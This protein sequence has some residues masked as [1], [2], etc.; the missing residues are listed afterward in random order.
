MF[1]LA[2]LVAV[3]DE[4]LTG[5]VMNSNAVWL[6]QQL[7][8]VGIHIHAQTVVGDSVRT[9]I[10][11]LR[12]LRQDCDLVVVT[13]GLGPT[14]DDVTKEA[15]AQLYQRPVTVD[16]ETHQYISEHHGR[17]S[18]WEES[19]KKQASVVSGAV[20]WQNPKG[21]AP[22]EL[23]ELEG[24][25]LVL[26]PGP[27]RE[28]EAIV[29]Q[30]LLPWLRR[31]QG[32]RTVMRQSL[33]C[34][35][36]GEATL[37]HWIEPLLAGQHPKMGIYAKPGQVDIRVETT[38]FSE[39][40]TVLAQRALAWVKGQVQ[41]PLYHVQ[42]VNRAQVIVETLQKRHETCSMMESLTGGLLAAR[43]IEVPGAS[44]CVSGGTVAYTDHVKQL[45]GVPGHVLEE[46]GAVSAE[47]AQ[48]MAEAV[49]QRF[50]TDWGL[51]TTGY[52]GPG[53]GDAENPVGTFYTA[54]SHKGQTV[55]RKRIIHVDRQGVREAAVEMAL[56][57]LWDLLELPG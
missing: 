43:L 9:I 50:H 38:A 57:Q 10:Q 32:S 1:K 36:I 5:E 6:A 28:M 45:S 56:T 17:N 51:S 29:E 2:G 55:V 24:Q 18:G 12:Y 46:F 47:C 41:A 48:A 54:V 53:G 15:V 4:V 31:M 7:L 13:G 3:G 34:F 21:Q 35:D 39:H 40:G 44:L 49:C 19:I 26:L 16:S 33:S 37:A 30:Y 14:A 8:S 22:G 25:T 11:A 52:A 20:I 42:G 27:P 23:I